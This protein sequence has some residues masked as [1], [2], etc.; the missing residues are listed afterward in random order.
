M[1]WSCLSTKKLNHQSK[2]LVRSEELDSRFCRVAL[3]AKHRSKT[4]HSL[5]GIWYRPEYWTS[6]KEFVDDNCEDRS[7]LLLKRL[8]MLCDISAQSVKSVRCFTNLMMSLN[9]IKIRLKLIGTNNQSWNNAKKEAT[10]SSTT[11][12]ENSLTSDEF[13]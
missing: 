6:M 10:T 5:L 9:K 8:N 7:K 3:A 2:S 13:G 12:Q 4:I 11:C 1:I